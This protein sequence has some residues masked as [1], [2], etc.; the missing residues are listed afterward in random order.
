M[1]ERKQNF[2]IIRFIPSS[3]D[4]SYNNAVIIIY[5]LYIIIQK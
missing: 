2:E 3:S 4:L 1:A 5:S